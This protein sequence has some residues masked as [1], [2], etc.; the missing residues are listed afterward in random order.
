MIDGN[1][2]AYPIC[3]LMF[4]ENWQHRLSSKHLEAILPLMD[5]PV[6]SRPQRLGLR[7]S[8]MVK[9]LCSNQECDQLLHV[10]I[11]VGKLSQTLVNSCQ[12]RSREEREE[13]PFIWLSF[14][15]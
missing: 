4:V 9:K 10:S 5:L 1:D 11:F 13:V 15:V 2:D 6:A 12:T 14:T 7:I 8:S 3:L